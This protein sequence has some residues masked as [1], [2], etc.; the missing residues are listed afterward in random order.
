[1]FN[2]IRRHKII[3][4]LVCINLIAII[5]AIV[6]IAIHHAKTATININ[7]AP[8]AAI[9][10][11]NGQ[12]YN[13]FESYDIL[14]GDYRVKI[15]MDGMQ[16]KEYNLHLENN[17]FA[18]IWD[19]LLD[20][21]GSFTY[22]LTHPDDFNTLANIASENDK[23]AQEFIAYYNRVIGIYD[24]LPVIEE[25]PSKFG[26][27]YGTNYMYD[28]LTIEDGREQE[29]CTSH[30]CILATDTDGNR[31]KQASLIISKLGYN[32]EDYQIIYKKV[33]YE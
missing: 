19:Y 31:E 20:T 9:I 8:N 32:P 12:S 4:G 26:D 27:M 23:S 30:I 16:T 3:S 14:P 2:F 28:T 7:V 18:R 33:D 5:I 22:Y 10:T 24:N 13:N 15:A 1:M 21:D 11:L 25:T 6:V 29:E 17:G